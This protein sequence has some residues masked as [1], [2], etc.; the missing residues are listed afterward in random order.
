MA[1]N[2]FLNVRGGTGNESAN[3]L[4]PLAT[5]GYLFNY[6]SQT[7]SFGD[8]DIVIEKWDSAFQVLD[9]L[10]IGNN[11]FDIIQQVIPKNDTLFL[12]GQI[13]DPA[14]SGYRAFVAKCLMDGTF[15]WKKY[16]SVYSSSVG[17]SYF[18]FSEFKDDTI[19][20]AGGGRYESTSNTAATFSMIHGSTGQLITENHS[21]AGFSGAS[22]TLT[23]NNSGNLINFFPFRFSSYQILGQQYSNTG[24]L[25]GSYAITGARGV[26][27][28][29]LTLPSDS[30]LLLT[31]RYPNSGGTAPVSNLLSKHGKDMKPGWAFSYEDTTAGSTIEIGSMD[32]FGGEIILTGRINGHASS[33]GLQDVV[34]ISIDT[35]G[36]V[37]WGKIIGSS[38]ID[39]GHYVLRLSDGYIIVGRT[40]VST[41]GGTDLL[42]IKTDFNG[43]VANASP[44]F[45]FIDFTPK[46]TYVS[47]SRVSTTIPLGTNT[48]TEFDVSPST[49]GISGFSQDPCSVLQTPESETDDSLVRQPENDIQLLQ[50]PFSSDL[51]MQSNLLH[52][53]QLELQLFDLSGREVLR[54][55]V[56]AQ[57]G[58]NEIRLFGNSLKA[59][60]YL[61]RLVSG[62]GLVWSWKVVKK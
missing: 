4:I 21:S 44:C 3:Q 8:Y 31:F 56:L 28:R 41:N 27:W 50:N 59:G 22:R 32:Y 49:A 40:D 38:G 19:F 36:N 26:P 52:D 9:T 7:S 47:L 58:K 14:F 16:H 57:A 23:K 45:S 29:S 30:F 51:R 37:N 35:L 39:G 60:M 17:T 1:Q 33:I 46:A 61:L 42:I 62:A 48:I 2:T 10:R 53:E 15:F 5:G 43:N 20:I 13:S 54:R 18:Y 55:T 24:S 25:L 12:I 11:N 34:L 6:V